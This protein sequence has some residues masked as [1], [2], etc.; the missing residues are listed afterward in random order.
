[1]FE[2]RD[3]DRE[4]WREW[5]REHTTARAVVPHVGAVQSWVEVTDVRDGLVSF[6]QT[7]VLGPHGTVLTSE[8]TL[9]FRTRAQL[10]D[11]VAAAGL[12][13]DDVRDAPDRPGRE[14]V[15]LTRRPG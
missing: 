4:A 6:R 2:S 15:F 12:V 14:L 3:P 1:M 13:V 9:R 11:S 5:D 10:A 8:S 7:F